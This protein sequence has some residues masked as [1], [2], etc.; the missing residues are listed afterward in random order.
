VTDARTERKSA[1]IRWLMPRDLVRPKYDIEVDRL[2]RGGDMD[3]VA[4][5][6]SHKIFV[7][8]ASIESR[9]GKLHELELMG[10]VFERLNREVRRP[11]RTV[12][13]NSKIGSDYIIEVDS[14][15][16]KVGA[17]VCK[18]WCEGMTALGQGWNGVRVNSP[19]GEMLAEA[20]AEWVEFG[21][22]GESLCD[23]EG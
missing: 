17:A 20:E 23:E 14:R 9:Y 3:K 5:A 10:M 4:T 22:N 1:E 2:S 16:L 11:I 15:S 19:R 7:A 8:H 18:A 13:C 6:T 12:F 21:P